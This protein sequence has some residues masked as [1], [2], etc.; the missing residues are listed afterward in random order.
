M[1]ELSPEHWSAEARALIDPFA[2]LGVVSPAESHLARLLCRLGEEDRAEMHLAVALA[3]RAPR[4]GHTGFV[5]EEI[6]ATVVAEVP[7]GTPAALDDLPWPETRA[8]LDMIAS[9]P[10]V[11]VLSGRVGRPDPQRPMVLAGEMLS[12]QRYWAYER[13]VAENLARRLSGS[14]E[15][16]LRASHEGVTIDGSPSEDG[17]VEIARVLL[18]GPGSE[19]QIDA[20]RTAL[21]RAVTVLT[22]GPGTGKTTTVAAL[23][24]ALLWRADHTVDPDG[25][26]GVQRRLEVALAAPTGKAAARLSEAFR[27]AAARLPAEV[28]ERLSISEA[29]TI[30]RL[31]GG[32]RRGFAHHRS[33]PLPHDVVI[34]DE[35]SMVSLPLIARL[36][37]AIPVRS[38]LVIV[39]DPGQLASVEAGTVL[40]DLVSAADSSADGP[41]TSLAAVLAGGV[42][43]LTTSRRFSQESGIGRLAAAI[44]AGDS[45]GALEVLGDDD[46]GSV[47]WIRYPEERSATETSFDNA[48]AAEIRAEVVPAAIA[49]VHAARSGDRA[50]ALAS[51]ERVRLLCAHRRGPFGI[52]YWN[53]LIRNWVMAETGLVPIGPWLPGEPVLVTANDY[54]LG[55][56]NGDLGTTVL[57]TESPDSE[58]RAAGR[59]RLSAVFGDPTSPESIAVFDPAQIDSL[60]SAHAMT[61]HKSQ[62]SEFDHVVVVLPPAH[63]RLAS[64]EL[65]YTAV[66]RARERIT[67]VGSAEMITAAVSRPVKRATGLAEELH[68]TD[69]FVR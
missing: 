33:R 38:R 3:A 29:S 26:P 46:T 31:L 55:L 61:I 68:A 69:L 62:G 64:R 2:R 60:E 15:E 39:G 25:G 24:A 23:L 7:V 36:L 10:L 13:V 22:G 16:S 65:L 49:A 4:L 52:G 20:V 35:A 66:T 27:S 56:F 53:H 34:L 41:R 32:S 37:D 28:A 19:E 54:R 51:L 57:A 47:R 40:A 44:T 21:D 11:S 59:R 1:S 67:V 8:W 63:S 5:P 30:H 12:L 48:V 9:S 42:V 14:L 58:M 50:T 45:A 6:A 18:S 17:A 43:R